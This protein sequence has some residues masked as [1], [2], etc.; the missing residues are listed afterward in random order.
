MIHWLMEKIGL[1]RC[2]GCATLVDFA[3]DGLEGKQHSKVREH[4]SGCPPCMEQVRD[5][6]QV[7]EGLGLSAPLTDCPEGFE[8]R[9][10]QR[11]KQEAAGPT[12]QR[13][14]FIPIALGGWPLF[15]L[16]LGP[17]FA[18]LSLVMTG[19]AFVAVVHSGAKAGAPNELQQ[20]TQAL[21]SDPQA[22]HVALAGEKGVS[23]ELVLCRGMKTLYL[24]VQHLVPCLQGS[25][26]VLWVQAQGAPAAHR[27]AAFLV[28]ATG[29]HL[30]LLQLPQAFDT[31]GPAQFTLTQEGPTPKASPTG[32]AW[33]AGSATL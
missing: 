30:Q 20:M 24:K 22:K 2:P 25:Q 31:Q 3:L 16:R 26:Y 7:N 13:P 5:F 27:L 1:I 14:V 23:G 33:L 12:P 28:E 11:L 6:L 10:L 21:L 18:A 4:L 15:W 19:V 8:K 32:P 9:V 17:I 29:P